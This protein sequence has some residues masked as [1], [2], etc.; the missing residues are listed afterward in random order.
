MPRI[1]AVVRRYGAY[2]DVSDSTDD[3]EK[4]ENPGLSKKHMKHKR[5][6]KH[7]I[8]R[9]GVRVMREIR[10]YQKSTNLLIQKS[11]FARL[12]KSTAKELTGCY[13]SVRFCVE[14]IAALQEAAEAFLVQHFENANSCTLHRNRVT[15]TIR[16]VHLVRKLFNY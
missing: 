6:N 9:Q 15:L 13:I 11:P 2:C 3:S 1:K 4:V 8:L 5:R 7:V 14:A 10:K 16:D 12:V